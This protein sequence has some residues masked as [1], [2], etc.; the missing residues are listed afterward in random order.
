MTGASG[1]VGKALVHELNEASFNTSVLMRDGKSSVADKFNHFFIADICD[2]CKQTELDKQAF[3]QMLS[4]IDVVI[5]LAARVHSMTDETPESYNQYEKVNTLATLTLARR[6]ANAGVKRFIFLSTIKVNGEF[7]QTG[8]PFTERDICMPTAPYAIS[9]WKAE[10]GLMQI[11]A[12][13]NMEVVII[14]TPLIYGQGVKGNFAS[15]MRWIGRGIPLPF[16]AVSNQR[17]LLALDNLVNFIICCLDSPNA[18]NEV[19]LLSDGE[20]YSTPALIQKLAVA[21]GENVRLLS[22]PVC[23]MKFVARLLGKGDDAERLFGSLQID[24]RKARE[25]LGWSPVVSMEE[26]LSKVFNR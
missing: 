20:D 4:E 17:S 10:Q 9:K 21:Q 14:R 5:H 12:D 16:G 15:M 2:L 24:S 19:F 18:A 7:T 26:Q 23:C 6:A 22:I 1:F 25:L 13:T 8:S 11:A 3:N